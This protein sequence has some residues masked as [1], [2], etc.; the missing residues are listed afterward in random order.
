MRG[1]F[2]DNGNTR[3]A[4]R[5]ATPRG[6]STPA[7]KSSSN[8]N[9][10]CAQVAAICYRVTSRG[11][12]FLLVRTRGRRWTFPKGGVEPGLTHAQVAALEA[13][14]EAGVHGRMESAAFTRYRTSRAAQNSKQPSIITGAHL[15]EVLSLTSPKES[16][17]NPTWFSADKAKRR[18]RED[19]I[20]GHGA[21]LAKV[22]DLALLRIQRLN[23][24][25]EARVDPL[26]RVQLES[27]AAHSAGQTFSIGR[28]RQVDA[29][30]RNTGAALMDAGAVL[31]QLGDGSAPPLRKVTPIDLK[32]RR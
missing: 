21:E 32:V 29:R 4:I 15:C 8:G 22:I 24:P 26:R 12:E 23:L 31:P 11:P 10:V 13:F 7:F 16:K 6:H 17:R 25:V 14:E 2:I 5:P 9:E 3:L 27:S 18:L 28:S 30:W 19:R 20:R 1:A